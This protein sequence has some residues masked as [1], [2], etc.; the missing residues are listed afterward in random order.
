MDNGVTHR[1]GYLLVG[2]GRFVKEFRGKHHG[3]EEHAL[4]IVARQPG[5]PPLLK[6]VLGAL[7]IDE[8]DDQGRRAAARV[9]QD[10]LQSAV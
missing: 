10:S 1:V 9:L 5:R 2:G 6:R 4:D 8:G 7:Q 3:G